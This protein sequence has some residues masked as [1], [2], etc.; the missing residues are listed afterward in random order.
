VQSLN[1]GLFGLQL[2]SLI[3]GA[4]TRV[5]TFF[6][7]K[8]CIPEPFRASGVKTRPGVRAKKAVCLKQLCR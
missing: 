1:L 5:Q 7:F 8:V 2:A 3:L 6:I 4:R